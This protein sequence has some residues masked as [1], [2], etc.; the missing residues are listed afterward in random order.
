MS[1]DPLGDWVARCPLWQLSL[2]VVCLGF[3]LVVLLATWL[4]P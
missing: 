2:V 1:D 4:G 3:V